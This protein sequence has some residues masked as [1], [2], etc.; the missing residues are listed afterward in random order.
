MNDIQ[1]SK[2]NVDKITYSGSAT[3]TVTIQSVLD[4]PNVQNT[5]IGI[6]KIEIKEINPVTNY[7]DDDL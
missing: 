3:K 7:S 1:N 2:E 4:I 5:H 6:I